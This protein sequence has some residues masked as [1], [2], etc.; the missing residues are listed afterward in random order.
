MRKRKDG[1]LSLTTL[2]KLLDNAKS[3]KSFEDLRMCSTP[4]YK[5]GFLKYLRWVK[6]RGFLAHKKNTR[7]YLVTQKGRDFLEMIQ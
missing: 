3:P 5:D 2:Y 4:I 6:Q 1:G 7:D